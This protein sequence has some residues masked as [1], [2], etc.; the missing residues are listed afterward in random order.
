[1][2]YVD[3]LKRYPYD[4]AARPLTHRIS[5]LYGYLNLE[6]GN[7]LRPKEKYSRAVIILSLVKVSCTLRYKNTKTYMR[8]Q[9]KTSIH[10]S[11][12]YL[13]AMKQ[14]QKTTNLL[15]LCF[16]TIVI[17]RTV[18][19]RMPRLARKN[20]IIVSDSASELGSPNGNLHSYLTCY[21]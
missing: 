10:L 12:K 4:C 8:T 3:L 5:Q 18:F 11:N 9:S 21:I 6:S 16:R 13:N 7:F 17:I 20:R 2:Q 14:K 19:A 1:M 15:S